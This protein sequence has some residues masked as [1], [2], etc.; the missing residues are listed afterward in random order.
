M[1]GRGDSAITTSRAAEPPRI[2]STTAASWAAYGITAVT[3]APPST[4]T[5]TP[6]SVP[7]RGG[8]L[9][10]FPSYGVMETIAT[11]W[12]ETGVFDKLRAAVGSILMEPKGSGNTTIGSNNNTYNNKKSSNYNSNNTSN[13][14]QQPNFMLSGGTSK[15]KSL[16]TEEDEG[17]SSAEF[18]NIVGQFEHS[19]KTYGGCVLLAVCRY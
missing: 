4:T 8:V 14:I 1:T 5:S 11:R 13:T 17:E 7:V 10:F 18:R 15:S 16:T 2:T 12:K 19:I 9:I 3:R 6:P